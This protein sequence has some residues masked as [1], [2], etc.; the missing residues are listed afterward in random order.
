VQVDRRSE[1]NTTRCCGRS[2]RMEK[3]M[4]E[5]RTLLGCN[6]RSSNGW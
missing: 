3:F 6:I 2:A 5:R 4:K 1:P